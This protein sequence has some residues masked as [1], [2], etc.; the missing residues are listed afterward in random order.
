L[1][2]GG[3]SHTT[4]RDGSGV[5]IP[6]EAKDFSRLE[7]IPLTFIF[8]GYRY[9]EVAGVEVNP[10]SPAITEVKNEWSYTSSP[11]ICL[12][13]VDRKNLTLTL[14]GYIFEIRHMS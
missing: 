11:P 4:S 2:G 9:W 8:N 13:G 5:R 7:N 12:Q 14:I 3:G 1:V 6:V 10:S